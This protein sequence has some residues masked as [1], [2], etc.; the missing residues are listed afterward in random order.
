[1]SQGYGFSGLGWMTKCSAHALLVLAKII[2][3]YIRSCTGALL[4]VGLGAMLSA[5]HP[6]NVSQV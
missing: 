6:S 4:E 5:L 1:M 3:F 2:S